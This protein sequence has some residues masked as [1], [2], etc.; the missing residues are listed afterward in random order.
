MTEEVTLAASS[1]SSHFGVPM[2][3]F[4]DKESLVVQGHQGHLCPIASIHVVPTQLP[5]CYFSDS[6]GTECRLI[7]HSYFLEREAYLSCL[8]CPFPT[9]SQTFEGTDALATIQVS[10]LWSFIPWS[11]LGLL[12]SLLNLPVRAWFPGT[13]QSFLKTME[14]KLPL[15]TRSISLRF[16]A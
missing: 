4:G 1:V 5:A 6:L 10:L 16:Q 12:Q 11:H 7:H 15:A 3:A 8:R 2:P 14:M 13:L 9:V